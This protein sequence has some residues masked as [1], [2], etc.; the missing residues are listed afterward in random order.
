MLLPVWVPVHRPFKWSLE[1]NPTTVR[2]LAQ[3]YLLVSRAAKMSY[4][5]HIMRTQGPLAE[6]TAESGGVRAVPRHASVMPL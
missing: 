4:L 1:D 5:A 6:E 3:F 2:Q